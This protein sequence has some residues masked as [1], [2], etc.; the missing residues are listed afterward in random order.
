VGQSAS[1]Y[2]AKLVR[3][4][5]LVETRTQG[6]GVQKGVPRTVLTLST[7][8]LQEADRFSAQLLRYRELDTARVINN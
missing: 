4:G 8:G 3:A 7:A 1:G 5:L 6:G 2:G